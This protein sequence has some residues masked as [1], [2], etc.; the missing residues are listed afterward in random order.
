MKSILYIEGGTV[1][2][3]DQYKINNNNSN[4]IKFSLCFSKSEEIEKRMSA[5]FVSL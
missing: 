2:Y 3:E 4:I 5:F 1:I